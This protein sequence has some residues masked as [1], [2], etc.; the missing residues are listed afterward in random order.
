[1]SKRHLILAVLVA[2]LLSLRLAIA[3]SKESEPKSDA[4]QVQISID[5]SETPE[6]EDWVKTKLRP[7]LEEWY[8]RIV[9]QL[10]GPDFHAPTM[11]RIKFFANMKGVADTAGT[12]VRCAAPWFKKNLDGEAVGA[13]VH[14]LVHV[15]Q[16]YHSGKN[17]GWL[18]EG[19]A[20]YIRWFEYEPV[21][22]RPHVN[23]DRA[24]YTD[25]YR[26]TA[27]F[28]NFVVEH[29]DKELVRKLNDT[30]RQGHYSPEVWNQLTGKSAQELWDEFADGLRK[31]RDAAK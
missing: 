9:E 23:P 13:V 1:M 3:E 15:V 28:L 11:I 27:A 19:I 17:P 24:K 6:L 30:M 14:E 16:Q 29:H 8:P 12:R 2:G 10:P 26:T 31:K 22:K 7:V 5:T 21:S 4:G 25:S 18:V 20:D